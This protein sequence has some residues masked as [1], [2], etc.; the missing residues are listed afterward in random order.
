MLDDTCLP[1]VQSLEQTSRLYPVPIRPAVPVDTDSRA[2]SN[3]I[4]IRGMQCVH[5]EILSV[6]VIAERF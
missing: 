5:L 3:T 6:M 2:D 1:H 4:V